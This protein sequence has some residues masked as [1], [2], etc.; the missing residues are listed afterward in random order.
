MLF[1]LILIAIL[2]VFA[3][4]FGTRVA[5][6][7]EYIQI[8]ALFGESI[9]ERKG[10]QRQ[11]AEIKLAKQKLRDAKIRG[12]V[13]G[14]QY[15]EMRKEFY[16]TTYFDTSGKKVRV[17]TVKHKEKLPNWANDL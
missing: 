13:S 12:D 3:G 17:K 15:N 10:R 6:K 16:Q 4:Q 5:Y 9:T 11:E 2:F 14:F 1:L 8:P 7:D